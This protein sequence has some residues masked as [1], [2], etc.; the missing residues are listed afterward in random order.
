LRRI[1][2]AFF[3]IFTKNPLFLCE[4]KKICYIRNYG[5]GSFGMVL[6]CGSGAIDRFLGRT[7]SKAMKLNEIK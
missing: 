3:T 5:F 6:E 1:D 4:R 2:R 7:R